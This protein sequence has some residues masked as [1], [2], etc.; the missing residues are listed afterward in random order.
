MTD[1]ERKQRRIERKQRNQERKQ[2]L[3]QSRLDSAKRNV[4]LALALARPALQPDLFPGVS[5]RIEKLFG[6]STPKKYVSRKNDLVELHFAIAIRQ[7]LR[8]YKVS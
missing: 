8:Y 4:E 6:K 5:A 3:A 1:Q 2:R 7:L